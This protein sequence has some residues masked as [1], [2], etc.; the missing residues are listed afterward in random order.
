M[1]FLNM[2]VYVKL[3]SL[4]LAIL[5]VREKVSQNCSLFPHYWLMVLLLASFMFMVE[6]QFL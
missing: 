5:F 6:A 2:V 3:I 4:D 1:F